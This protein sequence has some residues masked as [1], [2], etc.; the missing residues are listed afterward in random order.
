MK[1]RYIIFIIALIIICIIGLV[2]IMSNNNGNR[3]SNGMSLINSKATNIVNKIR[4]NEEVMIYIND[5]K[6]KCGSCEFAD[7][8]FNYYKDLYN[9]DIPIFNINSKEINYIFN[10]FDYD[11]KNIF[12][13]TLLHI[14]SGNL[15]FYNEVGY[16]EDKIKKILIENQYIK[17]ENNEEF[18]KS[19]DGDEFVK[20]SM[21][22]DNNLFLLLAVNKK[23]YKLRLILNQLAKKYNFEYYI[24]DFSTSNVFSILDRLEKINNNTLPKDIFVTNNN[25]IVDSINSEDVNEIEKFIKEEL[26]K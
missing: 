22:Q 7:I 2:F 8:K 10:S 25:K 3:N 21:E 6:D 19:I 12:V 15:T 11:K 1:K 24:V 4:N 18:G 23:S 17:E 9:L 26:K 20:L 14:K 5:D 13:P 16:V